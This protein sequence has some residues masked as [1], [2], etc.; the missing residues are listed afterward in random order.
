MKNKTEQRAQ[1]ILNFQFIVEIEGIVTAG[2]SEVSGFEETIETEDYKEGGGYFVHKLPK[3]VIQSTLK[4]KRGMSVDDELWKWFFSCRNAVLNAKPLER[5]LIKVSLYGGDVKD[6]TKKQTY[7]VFNR[8]YP[9]KWSGTTLN[10]SN[11]SMVI[12][13]L[14]I[15]HEGMIRTK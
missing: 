11:S 9:I 14:E 7:F 8:A 5:K 4:L 10:A 3:G 12:E 6:D 1:K 13:E 2:F 15:A